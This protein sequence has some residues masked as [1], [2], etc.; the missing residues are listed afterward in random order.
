MMFIIVV[1]SNDQ[2]IMIRNVRKYSTGAYIT[3]SILTSKNITIAN[4]NT[5][6]TLIAKALSN[7]SAFLR[8]RTV[9]VSIN[10]IE[11]I[12]NITPKSPKSLRTKSILFVLSPTDNE[13]K[14]TAKILTAKTS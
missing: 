12:V 11:I 9:N 4:E 1:I 5:T 8:E 13:R 14:K 10:K 3:K 2:Q 6:I 7:S